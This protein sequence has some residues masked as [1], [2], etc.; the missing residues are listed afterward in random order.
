MIDPDASRNQGAY[1]FLTDVVQVLGASV[2]TFGAK[3]TLRRQAWRQ[4]FSNGI[5]IDS[6][7]HWRN[8]L[9]SDVASTTWRGD[10]CK[11]EA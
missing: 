9:L 7:P 5:G 6:T 1:A 2:D 11:G 10:P 3:S 4:L 8:N